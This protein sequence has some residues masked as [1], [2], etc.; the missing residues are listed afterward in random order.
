M[1]LEHAL[2]KRNLHSHEIESP[3]SSNQEVSC[4]GEEGTGDTADDW[5]LICANAKQGTK[6]KAMLEFQLLHNETKKYLSMN[7]DYHF[8]NRNCPG[9]PINGQLEICSE[10]ESSEFTKWKIHSVILVS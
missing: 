9:C 4:Y 10:S 5:K 6:L 8:N 1:R 2:T 7:M 3:I